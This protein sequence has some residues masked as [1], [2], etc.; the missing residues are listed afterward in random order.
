MKVLVVNRNNNM[1]DAMCQMRVLKEWKRDDMQMDFLSCHSLHSIMA[2]HTDLFDNVWHESADYV[3]AF[4]A[5]WQSKGYDQMVEFTVDWGEA[6]TIGLLKAW[7]KRTLN[8]VPSTDKPYFLLSNEEKITAKAVH[9]SVMRQVVDNKPQ[10]RKSMI[11]QLESVSC[12]ERGFLRQDWERVIDM[13]PSDVAIFY[14]PPI[15]WYHSKPLRE[16]PNL[17]VLP[18]YPVGETGAMTQLV[19]LNLMVHSGPLML[20]YACDAKNIVHIMFLEACS[21]NIVSI[22]AQQAENVYYNSNREVNWE[23]VQ[24]LINKYLA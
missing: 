8:F 15:A 10:F 19:D 21:P 6:C 24:G 23:Q 16:R 11:L 14:M 22:P 12:N 2:T 13:I 18:A 1:G 5:G 17:I 7:G 20:A 4:A 3:N 9:D